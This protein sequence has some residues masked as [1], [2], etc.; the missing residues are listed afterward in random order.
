M[1]TMGCRGCVAALLA[2]RPC[3]G[4]RKWVYDGD[5]RALRALRRAVTARHGVLLEQVAAM[6]Q[7]QDRTHLA[8]RAAVRKNPRRSR[9]SFRARPRAIPYRS[10]HADGYGSRAAGD[11]G[12]GATSSWW[13]GRAPSRACRRI[14]RGLVHA[15]QHG[16]PLGEWAAKNGMKEIGIAIPITQPARHARRFQGCL[17][18]ERRQGDCRM[19]MPLQ[20][21]DPS[22][23]SEAARMNAKA[24][25]FFAPTGPSARSSSRPRRDGLAKAGEAHHNRG[26]RRDVTG[27][28]GRGCAR[29]SS[30]YGT[31][32]APRHADN[33]AS[34]PSGRSASRQ[35]ASHLHARN[36][37]RRHARDCDVGAQ[38]G[39]SSAVTR[40][41]RAQGM[42][43]HQR[44]RADPDRREA[45]GTSCKLV[46]AARRKA[47]RRRLRQHRL[48]NHA[49]GPRPLEAA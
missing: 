28:D 16:Y 1:R 39:R 34:W 36:G 24:V 35:V 44:T 29:Q 15:L 5:E 13:P 22:S 10:P 43:H 12:Q 21:P 6:R 3:A 7:R 27:G 48:R 14:L 19:A 4:D 41:D 32:R 37:V 20:T 49:G 18:E 2:P 40:H 23:T 30:P 38:L 8:R 45:I 17:R 46:R 26:G 9:R 42:E 11:R 33:R 47:R 31:T 25:F